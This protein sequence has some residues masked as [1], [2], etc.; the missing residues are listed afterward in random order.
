M[1][2]YSASVAASTDDAD[3]VGSTVDISG[4]T[5]NAN[6]ASQRIGL[7]FTSVTIP[8]GATITAA[9]LDLEFT[10]SSFDDPDVTIYGDDTD[11]A[12]TFTAT[13]NDISN[14]T[15][16]TATVNWTASSV[17]TGIVTTPDIATIIQEIIDRAGWSSGNA[18]AVVIKGNGSSSFI[19]IRAY[20]GAGTPVKLNITYTT[21]GGSGQPPRTMHQFGQRTS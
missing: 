14:R 4:T 1:A 20:D 16:T 13:S 12:A 19:R 7:R 10:S 18:V 3:Q 9:T 8:P 2:T 15:Q 21:G 17:G 6:S 11:S 5:L